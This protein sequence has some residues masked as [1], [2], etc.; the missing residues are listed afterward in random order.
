[1]SDLDRLI[2]FIKAFQEVGK[3]EEQVPLFPDFA[4]EDTVVT[5]AEPLPPPVPPSYPECVFPLPLL[6]GRAAQVTSASR[7]NNK[8]RPTHQ[9][10]DWMYRRIASDLD[11][12]GDGFGTTNRRWIVPEG[13]PALAVRDG[14]VRIAQFGATST[15]HRLYV[16]HEDGYRSGYFHL[17]EILVVPGQFVRAGEPV[18]LVGDNPKV[19]DPR[20]LHFEISEGVDYAP[21]D[22]TEYLKKHG[23]KHAKP[24]GE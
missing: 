9:G 24:R 2:E 4:Q 16:Q 3:P 20:H 22:P 19:V 14:I 21:V 11:P 8:S 5:S 17:T 7:W 18:G 13:T 10:D 6:G 12:V 23:A 1:M 15:G